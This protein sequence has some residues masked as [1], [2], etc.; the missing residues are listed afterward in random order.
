MA[1]HPPCLYTEAYYKKTPLTFHIH[2][3]HGAAI[4]MALHRKQRLQVRA[5]ILSDYKHLHCI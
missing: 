5:P 1:T 2:D 3:I 4:K